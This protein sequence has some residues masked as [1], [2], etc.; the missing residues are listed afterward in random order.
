MKIFNGFQFV[1]KYSIE[2]IEKIR[3]IGKCTGRIF[4]LLQFPN[5]VKSFISQSFNVSS[6]IFLNFLNFFSIETLKKLKTLKKYKANFSIFLNFK[7]FHR[8]IEKIEKM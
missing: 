2:K 6:F 8:I 7:F 5:S 4:Q 3:K 1:L